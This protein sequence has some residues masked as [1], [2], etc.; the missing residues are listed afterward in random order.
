MNKRDY[1]CVRL[2]CD[3]C[4]SNLGEGVREFRVLRTPSPYALLKP[5]SRKQIT[6]EWM[7]VRLRWA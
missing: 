6:T 5:F 2:E 4:A 7:D 3:L 1:F